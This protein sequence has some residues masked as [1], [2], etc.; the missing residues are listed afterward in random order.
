VAIITQT[1][2]LV[3]GVETYLEGVIPA[4]AK[5]HTLAF[6]SASDQVGDRGTIALPAN[7]AAWA[8]DT[9]DA[10]D[11]LQAFGPDVLFAHG[12]DDPALEARV[13]TMA[14]AVI[15]E[16]NYHGTCI[17]G[18]KTMSLPR[19]RACDRRFGPACLALYFPRRC[20]GLS[21]LTMVR[22]YGKQSARLATL[23]RCAAVVTLSGHMRD[24]ML[25]HGLPPE[26]V[27][28]VPPFVSQPEMPAAPVTRSDDAIRL[29]FIGRLE[30][31]KG[32]PRLL[33]ALP[34]VARGLSRRVTLTVA[35]DGADRH[36]LEAHAQRVERDEPRLKVHFVGW[37]QAAG[38][39]RLLA[40]SDAIV[41][42]SVWPEPFGLVGLE[43]A[44]AGVPAVAFATGGI[45]DWLKD[46][47]TGCLASAE[48][49]R[50]EALA[51]A[52][53]R[54]VGNPGVRARLARGALALAARWTIERHL[55]SLEA[56]LSQAACSASASANS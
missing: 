40:G 19:V 48:G 37:L 6:W 44:S 56:V 45:G 38:K 31:L 51:E 4:L 27:H 35:G 14:P 3:G 2:A 49:A 42:P 26:R 28:V 5:R 39:D 54:C 9:S 15:V 8:A 13:L 47:E 32:L 17:S 11:R 55:T 50:P 29:L 23:G 43:A 1:R 12:L 53:V 25:R 52:I 36:A 24:E 34:L 33:D 41:M 46:D 7:V 10:M 21:P 20:G 16:H 18:S 30:P 22:M